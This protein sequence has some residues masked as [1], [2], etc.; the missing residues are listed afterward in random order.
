MMVERDVISWVESSSEMLETVDNAAIY[1]LSGEQF[2]GIASKMSRIW[3]VEIGLRSLPAAVLMSIVATFDT[4]IADVIRDMLTIKTEVFQT[5]ERT[6]LL[7]DALRAELIAEIKEKSIVDEIY[8]FSRGS[9]EDQ[10]RYIETN[11]HVA[12]KD[13]WKRWPDFIEV[14]ERRNLIAHGEK[15]FTKRYASICSKNGHKGS[16][17]ILGAPVKLTSNYLRQAADILLEFSLLL[18][19][20][21]WRKQFVKEKE[22]AFESLNHAAF[23]LIETKKYEVAIR[24]L[25]YA[26]SLKNTGVLDRTRKMMYVNLASAHRHS[27]NKELSIRI[28]SDVDWSS[29]SDDFKICVAALR[30]DMDEV[31]RLMPIVANADAVSKEHFRNWPVFKFVRDQERFLLR[32]REIF[33]E[34]LRQEKAPKAMEFSDDDTDAVTPSGE[35]DVTVH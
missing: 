28:L 3:R 19:F 15:T 4:V 20:S 25:E 12:I 32:F 31:T 18:V 22:D 23:R 6:I 11:F 30:G 21:L 9:H 33:G 35:V 14:F 24:L 10:V 13:H 8:Q 29:S 26:L 2:Q 27:D 5:G 17:K 34:P 7:S 16:D 1:G